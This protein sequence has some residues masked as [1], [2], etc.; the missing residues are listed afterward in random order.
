MENLIAI[1]IAVPIAIVVFLIIL[2]LMTAFV[3]SLFPASPPPRFRLPA[4]EDLGERR[5]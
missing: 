4:S 5:E 3:S 2:V 1:V